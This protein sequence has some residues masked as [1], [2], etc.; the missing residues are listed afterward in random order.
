MT[1]PQRWAE[2]Y[3]WLGTDPVPTEPCTSPE[4]YA[5]EVERVFRRVWLCMGR[6]E[7][8]AEVGSYK[9]KR[10]DFASTDVLLIRG[11]DHEIRAFHNT[12]S[13]RGNNVVTPEG[14]WDQ[15]GRKKVFTCRF[16]AWSYDTEGRLAGVQ[17]E[18]RFPPCFQKEQNGLT[19]I[20]CDSWQGFVFV[21]L[22]EKPAQPLDEFLG[23]MGEHFAGYPYHELSHNFT[24][25]TVLNC[26]WKIGVDAFSE[27]YHVNTIHAGSFPGTFSTGLQMVKLYGDHRT[28]AVCFNP[29]KEGPPVASLA[30]QKARGSL[31]D[32]VA[33]T[34]L[35]PTINDEKRNDFS[36]ELSVF[37]PNW[38]LH[39]AEGIWFTHQFWPIG[40]DRCLWEGK[41]YV[42]PP[43]T[44]SERWA[45]EHAIVLQRNA[46]LEDTATM[47]GTFFSLRS[48]AKKHMQLQDEEILVRHGY[49]VLEQYLSGERP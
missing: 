38:L 23:A 5:R 19:E 8:I 3:P 30:Q 22:A 36:F 12:C 34:M 28:T 48:G 29:P 2:S 24:Y 11:K 40:H 49:H 10:L 47:E 43:R 45:L 35:P 44:N 13:H 37:F 17:D 16:H 33:A 46:W 1:S 31:V 41:Y 20:H 39:V 9:L 25:H 6:A 18:K 26:N 14:S 7:E 4:V 27:A 15:W 32:N 21:N 42:R